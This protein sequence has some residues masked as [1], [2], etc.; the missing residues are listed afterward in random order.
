MPGS[1]KRSPN[2]TPRWPEVHNEHDGKNKYEIVQ[3]NHVEVTVDVSL[4]PATDEM[5]FNATTIAA[6]GANAGG[7][8]ARAS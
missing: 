7:S 1:K 2:G 4:L 5:H 6:N 3:V 8:I